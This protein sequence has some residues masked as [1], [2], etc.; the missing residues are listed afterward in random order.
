MSAKVSSDPVAISLGP[1][2]HTAGVERERIARVEFDRPV[3]VSSGTDEITRGAAGDT[4]VEDR[5]GELGIEIDGTV[6]VGD[7]PIEIK[8]FVPIEALH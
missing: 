2:D 5:H 8:L 3:Q 1:T 4:P 7:G 6:T